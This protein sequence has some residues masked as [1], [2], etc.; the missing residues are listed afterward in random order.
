MS[1]T[2]K[3]KR[4]RPDLS[5]VRLDD[6]Q[7]LAHRHIVHHCRRNRAGELAS[8]N[9]HPGHIELLERIPLHLGKGGALHGE[10]VHIASGRH[11]K[12]VQMTDVTAVEQQIV[13]EAM[14]CVGHQVWNVHLNDKDFI[15]YMLILKRLWES[16][17]H[18]WRTSKSCVL[19][20]AFEIEASRGWAA[21]LRRSKR[22]PIVR[23]LPGWMSRSECEG[24]GNAAFELVQRNL[25]PWAAPL[26]ETN[27]R[28][29]L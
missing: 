7:S 13:Q 3:L 10:T 6:G 20:L 28:F 15:H 17:L 12:W 19:H 14:D 27:Q 8:A 18:S 5:E 29:G 4:I 26:T 9:R 11:C 25:A 22:A 1:L 2:F 16:C 24:S 21:V 23:W